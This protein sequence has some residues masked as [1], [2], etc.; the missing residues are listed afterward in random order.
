MKLPAGATAV[1]LV[2]IL[3]AGC[4]GSTPEPDIESPA[5]IQRPTAFRM[6]LG[7]GGGVTGQWSG[8]TLEYPTDDEDGSDLSFAS[9][10][11]WEGAAA[12]RNPSPWAILDSTT[13]YAIW[14]DLAES[15]GLLGSALPPAGEYTAFLQ[16]ETPSTDFVASWMPTIETIEEAE[17]IERLYRSLRARLDTLS[18]PPD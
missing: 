18:V 16:V 11:R 14:T 3:L 9:V 5:T 2:G 12:E 13:M 1:A 7:E 6:V 15:T 10:I 4:S 17:P 8:Y